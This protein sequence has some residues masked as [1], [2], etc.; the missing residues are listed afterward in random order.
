M[1]LAINIDRIS[2]VC[3]SGQWHD[4]RWWEESNGDCN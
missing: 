2:R 4:V 1:T 3:I